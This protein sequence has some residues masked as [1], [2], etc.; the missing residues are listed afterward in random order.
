MGPKVTPQICTH[1]TNINDR[2]QSV[3]PQ[4]MHLG[5]PTL[6]LQEL[7]GRQVQEGLSKLALLS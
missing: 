1:G 4:R 7:E 6:K 3:L 5:A 2:I